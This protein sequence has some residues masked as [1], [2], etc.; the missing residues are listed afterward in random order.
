LGEYTHCE[1]AIY[2]VVRIMTEGGGVGWGVGEYDY[3][4]YGSVIEC[5]ATCFFDGYYDSYNTTAPSDY[6]T[7]ENGNSDSGQSGSS[8]SST[9]S[10][11]SGY[12]SPINSN[13]YYSS[14]SS[15][16]DQA[17]DY[18]NSNSNSNDYS[19]SN[20][21]DYSNSNSNGNGNDYSNS[22][23]NSNGNGYGK[24]KDNGNS[25]SYSNGKD[26]GKDNGNGNGKGHGHKQGNGNDN[27][28]SGDIYNIASDVTAATVSLPD[29]QAQNLV[30]GQ[31]V[32]VGA[33]ATPPPAVKGPSLGLFIGLPLAAFVIAAV[34]SVLI[35]R[36]KFAQSEIGEDK[37]LEDESNKQEAGE[38]RQQ[39]QK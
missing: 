13:Y 27:G 22:N 4:T 9:S 33:Q 3:S 35:L 23:S 26:N 5:Q 2:F 28:D 15:P 21:N 20:S 8:Y 32:V 16:S 30:S 31:A 19:N 1:D 18:S 29:G 25:Y 14:P 6:G 10:G 39:Q 7:P 11:T 12:Y 36:K 38:A 34:V 17:N 37:D 24:G